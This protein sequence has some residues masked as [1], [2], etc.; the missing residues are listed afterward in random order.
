MLTRSFMA[1]ATAM[2]GRLSPPTSAIVVSAGIAVLAFQVRISSQSAL[3]AR[4]PG[5][6]GGAPAAGQ[7]I[8]GLKPQEI[9]YFNA[10]KDEFEEAEEI[11]EGIGPRMN[12]DSCGGCHSQ[13]ALGG[14]SPALNPQFAFSVPGSRREDGSALP[15]PSV[16]IR[17]V[18]QRLSV[19]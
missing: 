15:R 6:R 2:M 8:A 17:G 12:L 19:K 13:P 9:E 5:V 14:S 1:R 16:F 11:S 10:G 7:P 4:D 18:R 3:V